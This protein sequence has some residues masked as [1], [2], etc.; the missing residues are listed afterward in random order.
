LTPIFVYMK[1]FN[2]LKNGR[3][4]KVYL[5][6]LGI[7]SI[8]WFLI[9]VIPKPSRA[10]YPCMVATAPFMSAFILYILS[11]ASSIWFLKRNNRRVILT[12]SI[13][14]FV[15]LA[16]PLFS[17]SDS[18][19]GTIK[20]V[21]V[22]YYAVN[23]PIGIAKGIYPGRVVWI[24]DSRA[25][26]KTFTNTAGDYWFMDKNS[27]QD[28]IEKM[29]N[30]SL[31][32]ISGKSTSVEAWDAVFRHYNMNHGKGDVGYQPGESIAVKINLTNSWNGNISPNR[33]DATPQL[34]LAL[35]K[36]L[37]DVAGVSQSD[38][39]L[40]DSYRFFRTEYWNKCH[41]VYPDVHYVDEKGINGREQTQ[42]SAAQLLR[43]SDKINP[44][45]ELE[46]TSSIPQH[47]VDAAYFINMPCLKS[48]E[49]GGITIA[50]KNHQGSI[51]AEGTPPEDQFAAFMH[52]SL[53]GFNSSHGSYRHLVDFMGHKDLGGKTL[54][55]IVDGIWAGR[56]SSGWLEKWNM[57]PFNG[58]YPSSLFVSQDAV[59]I[60]SVCFDFLLAEYI[61]KPNSIKHPYIEGTDDYLLQ[62]ADPSNWPAGIQYDP[63][64][65]GTILSSLGVY[66]HWN[67]S[68]D[69]QYSR[70]LV[71]G[72]G[73]ELR[74]LN[75]STALT[76]LM[77]RVDYELYPNPF[78]ETLSLTIKDRPDGLLVRVCNS[79][80]QTVLSKSVTN[81]FVWD[82][83]DSKGA[84][85]NPGWYVISV[86][87]DKTGELI[88]SEKI[89][90]KLR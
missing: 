34:V 19:S 26:S 81:T 80:G 33:M 36:Q 22:G 63:E 40:G 39:W 55:Y 14:F 30:N 28:V 10:A 45:T 82:G 7:A 59:A 44:T 5:F 66:E 64:G 47:Y 85:I 74:T 11:L 51:L 90:S 84:R 87:D 68:I 72:E 29:L 57:A 37:I 48:H 56:E 8:A 32:E 77:P 2:H 27:N 76:K 23:E 13:L 6:F 79:K 38:I 15:F 31:L 4:S 49:A 65:D 16:L 1:L 73:I 9:R 17:F 86:F 89:I 53:P 12:K 62:A 71:T 70:N 18:S 78:S 69:K 67:N 50:A 3:Q 60:E 83:R 75:T 88:M 41:T 43:F 24:H 42:P 20:H 35:L 58:D 46:N 52:Y 61:N 21:D 25:T 54:L